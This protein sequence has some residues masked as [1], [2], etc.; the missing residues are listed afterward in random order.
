MTYRPREGDPVITPSGVGIVY[1][2]LGI[3]TGNGAAVF[4]TDPVSPDGGPKAIFN[5]DDLQPG[6]A[7]PE[8]KVTDYV[9]VPGGYPGTVLQ[10]VG[11]KVLCSYQ[12]PRTRVMRQGVFEAWRL[13]ISNVRGR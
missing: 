4:M 10:V 6:P 8:F 3:P 11:G 12:R 5:V 2:F 1:E 13:H 7:L 9:T